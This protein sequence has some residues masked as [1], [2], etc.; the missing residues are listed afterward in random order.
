ME[1]GDLSVNYGQA[2][3]YLIFLYSAFA[4]GMMMDVYIKNF[5]LYIY[6]IY[7]WSLRQL[8]WIV[9]FYFIFI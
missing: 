7:S 9:F 5:F 2:S 8:F 1:V 6:V 3:Y 4:G